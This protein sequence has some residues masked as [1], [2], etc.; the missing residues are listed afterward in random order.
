MVEVRTT[1]KRLQ[2]TLGKKRENAEK[3]EEIEVQV[4]RCIRSKW[5]VNFEVKEEKV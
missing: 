3:C 5:Q 1:G 2:M 4:L